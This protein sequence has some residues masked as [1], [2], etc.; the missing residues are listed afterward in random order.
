[1]TS[2]LFHL[3]F[4]CLRCLRLHLWLLLWLHANLPWLLLHLCLL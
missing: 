3:S 4:L 2:C 1:M